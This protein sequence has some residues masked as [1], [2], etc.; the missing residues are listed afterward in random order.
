MVASWG[1]VWSAFRLVKLTNCIANTDQCCSF[2][3]DGNEYWNRSMLLIKLI[4]SKFVTTFTENYPM[5][6]FI[7]TA[8]GLGFANE[9]K[10]GH[11]NIYASS[12]RILGN[13]GVKNILRKLHSN[14]VLV[15][16]LAYCFAVIYRTA[17]SLNAIFKIGFRNPFILHKRKSSG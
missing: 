9:N 12:I 6:Y 13:N 17:L 7:K 8:I 3:P 16:A 15:S 1:Y 4:N 5:A 11:W 10:S 14:H 2:I